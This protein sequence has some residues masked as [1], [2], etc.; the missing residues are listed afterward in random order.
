[1]VKLK[2]TCEE[3]RVLCAANLTLTQ[4]KACLGKGAKV[5]VRHSI[6]PRNIHINLNLKTLSKVFSYEVKYFSE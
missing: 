4:L 2:L 1:M 3:E 5:G 6:V